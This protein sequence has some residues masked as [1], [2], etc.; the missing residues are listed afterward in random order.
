MSQD[1][2]YRA[3]AI[4]YSVVTL[5]DTPGRYHEQR[6]SDVYLNSYTKS[7][8]TWIRFLFAHLLT[9]R[10]VD[11]NVIEEV[12]PDI[13]TS[14]KKA[15]DGLSD[16]RL[17]KTHEVFDPRFRRVLYIIRDPRDVCVSYFHWNVKYKI[18][19]HD[20]FD[21][22]F[23]QYLNGN[24]GFGIWSDH[25]NSRKRIAEKSPERVR[26]FRYEDLKS[27]TE[28]VFK[29]MVEFVGLSVSQD[30]IERA[31]L[32]SDF[33]EMKKKEKELVDHEF[34][35]KTDLSIP[36]VRSGKSEWR[37]HLTKDQIKRIEE[38]FGSEMNA[39]GYETS[40]Y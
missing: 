1:L 34:V 35:E 6:S 12:V 39:F 30:Q 2:L 31:L 18:F 32:G 14:T 27:D 10:P 38:K 3:K 26:F 22:Y 19:G 9:D 21:Q 16:P 23:D 29:K 4:F 8:N 40:Y 17:I 11:F 33:T 15:L 25:I 24:L 7:G 5:L 36:F 13:Y 28:M 37:Q 20:E